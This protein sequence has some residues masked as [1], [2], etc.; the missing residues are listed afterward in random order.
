M[1]EYEMKNNVLDMTIARDALNR[2]IQALQNAIITQCPH[3]YLLGPDD[4]SLSYPWESHKSVTCHNC[5]LT[6]N[7]SNTGVPNTP[8]LSLKDSM[9]AKP[10]NGTGKVHKTYQLTVEAQYALELPRRF[11]T[12]RLR[13]LF[14]DSP[15]DVNELLERDE[16][17][18]VVNADEL[19]NS[20]SDFS[21]HYYGY[22]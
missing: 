13:Q 15:F 22:D 6:V 10:T 17:R 9:L 18:Y 2:K 11:T 8:L 3:T 1:T 7:G 16:R 19:I 20:Y 5:G 12:E 14:V 4:S 21:N